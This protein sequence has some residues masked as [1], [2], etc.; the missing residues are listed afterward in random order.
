MTRIPDYLTIKQ[1]PTG[2]AVNISI[3]PREAAFVQNPYA[4]YNA[5]HHRGHPVFFWEQYGLWCFAGFDAV[6]ALFRDKRFGRQILH[7]ATRD[8]LGLA[9]RP[10]HLKNFDAVEQFSLLELEPPGHTR[11]RKLVNRAF[12]SRQV[13]LLRPQIESLCHRLIDGFSSCSEIDLITD[14]ATPIPLTTI[15]RMLGVPLEAGQQLLDWSHAI[16]KMYMLDPTMEDQLA[17]DKAAAEFAAFLREQIAIHKK[18]PCDDLL[19]RLIAETED[20]ECLTEAE[21]ISTVVVLLNAGHEATVHQLGN[22]VKSIIESGILPAQLFASEASAIATVE[23]CLRF[24]APLHMFTRYALED[25]ELNLEG[26][27]IVL[28]KGQKIGLLLGAANRDPRK[29][30]NPD[31]FW[32]ERPFQAN[33]SFGAGIHF[34]I[35]APLA[36]LELLVGLKTLFARI[37]GLKFRETPKYR[38]IFH[39]HGLDK[40][41]AG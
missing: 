14:Y 37:P 6:N 36:R 35:G 21:L 9:P 18:H 30:E 4:A 10:A 27:N 29:F 25:L 1:T 5:L 3:D 39:F 26:A 19:S 15:C 34:C 24:D 32:P 2:T 7:V 16:V 23:E 28:K 41:I 33:V 8:E 31:L 13:E 11:I 17:A 22:A 38:D 20:G 40:V 12:V